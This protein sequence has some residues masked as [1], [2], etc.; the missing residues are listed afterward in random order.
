[1]CAY[2]T[3]CVE[4]RRQLGEVGSLLPPRTLQRPT[5][6]C[7]STLCQLNYLTDPVFFNVNNESRVILFLPVQRKREKSQFLKLCCSLPGTLPTKLAQKSDQCL[8]QPSS[9]KLP[10]CSRQKQRQSPPQHNVRRALQVLRALQKRRQKEC[11]RQSRWGTLRKQAVSKTAQLTL[12]C[13][14]KDCDSI[15]RACTGPRQTDSS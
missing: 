6:C 14:Y 3:A 13:T 12:L 2:H 1:M 15:Y 9:E 8:P 7:L 4:M 5:S 11:T 10:S